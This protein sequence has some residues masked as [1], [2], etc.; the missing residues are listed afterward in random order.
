MQIIGAEQLRLI[1]GKRA[2]DFVVQ[3][4]R[5]SG[6]VLAIFLP[7]GVDGSSAQAI[8]AMLEPAPSDGFE[9]PQDNCRNRDAGE[10]ARGGLSRLDRGHGRPDTRPAPGRTFC[11]Q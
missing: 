5:Q 11:E 10:A 3:V 6:V 7:R 1:S 4:V 9:F 2:Q 8:D